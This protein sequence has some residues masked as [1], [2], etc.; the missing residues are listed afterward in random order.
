MGL[1]RIMAAGG[2]MLALAQPAAAQGF[3]PPEGC[4]GFMTVQSRGCRVSNHY[5]CEKDA[6]GAQRRA[7]FAHPAVVFLRRVGSERQWVGGCGMFRTG[8]EGMDPNPQD[9]ASFTELLGGTDTY[10]FSL[11]KDNGERSEVSG[12]DRLT[13]RTVVIDGIP[14]EET[15]FEFT[16][17]SI[18]GSVLRRARGREY[19]HRDWRL[20]FSGPTEWDAGDG[21]FVPVD[22][23]PVQFIFPGEPGFAATQPI[24]DCDAILSQS[25]VFDLLQR[26]RHDQ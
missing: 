14:L 23:S 17:T 22:G 6:P 25:P 11:S 20:F 21:S 19:I 26:A 12:F 18:G 13:G 24:F 15:A 1:T 10:A 4:T 7:A 3:T 2:L 8:A 16:E 5:R 9:P